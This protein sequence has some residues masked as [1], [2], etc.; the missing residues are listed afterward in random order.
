[1][2]QVTAGLGA[3]LQTHILAITQVRNACILDA[4]LRALLQHLRLADTWQHTRQALHR[5]PGHVLP[6]ACH[7]APAGLHP[8]N[9]ALTHSYTLG[10]SLCMCYDCVVQALLN[11]AVQCAPWLG[12]P[13]CTC[14]RCRW[15][16]CGSGGARCAAALTHQTGLGCCRPAQQARPHEG[17]RRLAACFMSSFMNTQ[18][19][20]GYR[21]APG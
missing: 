7:S 6:L 5:S 19:V 15:C 16:R 9:R 10:T 8:L 1:M 12:W 3:R 4:L 2:Q 18:D 17:R 14:W 11:C 20:V 21:E 13:S